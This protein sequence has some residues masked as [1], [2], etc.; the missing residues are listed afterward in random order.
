MTFEHELTIVKQL[1]QFGFLQ[2]M[3][4][5]LQ[6]ER[7]WKTMRDD[8]VQALT[9]ELWGSREKEIQAEK[10][11]VSSVFT[12][13]FLSLA[14]CMVPTHRSEE[15]FLY[16]NPNNTLSGNNF[17]N[18]RGK[19]MVLMKGIMNPEKGMWRSN[20]QFSLENRRNYTRRGHSSLLPLISN[21]LFSLCFSHVCNSAYCNR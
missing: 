9:L 4:L 6:W 5:D 10:V 7:D 20:Y 11:Y 19:Q 12:T 2:S 1:I 15:H 16:I 14:S 8:W 18:I 21:H 17:T 13:L 3:N